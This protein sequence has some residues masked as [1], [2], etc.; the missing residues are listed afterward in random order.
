MLANQHGVATA[1]LVVSGTSLVAWC[2]GCGSAK[3]PIKPVELVPPGSVV[4]SDPQLLTAVAPLGMSVTHR[5][6]LHSQYDTALTRLKSTSSC[7]CTSTELDRETLEPG[8]QATLTCVFNGGT[9]P[10]SRSV[11][12]HLYSP[13]SPTRAFVV[14]LQFHTDTGRSDLQ[15]T[16]SPPTITTNEL[17]NPKQVLEYEVALR[18]GA[19]VPRDAIDVSTSSGIIRAQLRNSVLRITIDSPPSGKVDE[20]VM[21]SF[22]RGLDTYSLKIPV[23]GRIRP[24]LAVTPQSLSFSD[25]PAG[26]DMQGDIQL[27]ADVKGM[28]TPKVG[29][30]GDWSLQSVER[31]SDR[32]W[33]VTVGLKQLVGEQIR[34]G[35]VIVDGDWQ[36]RDITIPISGS[37]NGSSAELTEKNGF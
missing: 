1:L 3:S 5:L 29:V 7:G 10:A 35:Q 23:T 30:N 31:V 13:N 26:D 2:T 18:L 19:G 20:F 25:V 12:I 22:P 32:E 15:V 24:L 21:L 14:D 16:A 34:Y 17:W 9:A 6:P 37:F 27:T 4:V 33:K 11:R 8:G 28:K 36:G